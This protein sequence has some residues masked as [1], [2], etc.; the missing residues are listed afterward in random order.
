MEAFRIANEFAAVDVRRQYVAWGH[1]LEIKD[2]R[3]GITIHLD[4]LEVEALTTLSKPE[5]EAL[6]NQSAGQLKRQRLALEENDD[7]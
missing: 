5:R 4:A 7:A 3:T 2:A 6:I 1:A